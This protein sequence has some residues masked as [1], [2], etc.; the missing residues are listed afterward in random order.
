MYCTNLAH[1]INISETASQSEGET[2]E[3]HDYP[4]RCHDYSQT[5]HVTLPT[6]PVTRFLN[7]GSMSPGSN[8]IEMQ[9][10]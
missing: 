9:A 2:L 3:A 7:L 8:E 6:F 1:A 5:G 10:S 4:C